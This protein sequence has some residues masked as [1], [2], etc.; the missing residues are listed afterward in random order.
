MRRAAE[1]Y[2]NQQVRMTRVDADAIEIHYLSCTVNAERTT[3]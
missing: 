1:N 3:P 2:V